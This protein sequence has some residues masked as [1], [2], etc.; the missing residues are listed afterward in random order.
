MREQRWLPYL[1]GVLALAGV[2]GC[3]PGDDPLPDG[4]VVAGCDDGAPDCS[5]AGTGTDAGARIDAGPLTCASGTGD[6]DGDP[7]NGC[8]TSLVG[9]DDHCG[10]CERS[11][12]AHGSTCSAT[13][14]AVVTQKHVAP[15]HA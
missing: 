6:C 15:A 1:V 4:G 2:V 12:S 3:A 13:L 9:N 14:C 8:E 7:S 11:C 5:D 10:A